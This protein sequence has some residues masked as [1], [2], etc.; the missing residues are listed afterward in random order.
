MNEDNCFIHLFRTPGGYYL[1]DVNRRV[2]LKIE[3]N[4]WQSFKNKDFSKNEELIN[5][6]KENGLLSSKRVGKIVHPIDA[7]LEH[8]LNNKACMITLQITQQCNLRCSYCIYSGDYENRE[9]SNQKMDIEIAK[10]G[11]DFLL[12]HSKDS[13]RISVGFYG[14]EPLLEF[15]LMKSVIKYAELKSEGKNIHFTFTTNAT[16]LDNEKLEFLEKY[17]VAV[18]ISLDGPKEVHDKNRK[19]AYNSCGTFDIVIDKL[20]KLREKYPRF[21][22]KNISFNAVI[23]P[24]CD[25]NCTNEFFTSYDAVKNSYVKSSIFK[26][27]YRKTEIERT[28]KFDLDLDYEYFKVF[29]AMLNRL[30][31]HYISKMFDNYMIQ[32]DKLHERLK[33]VLSLPDK[34]HHGGPCIPGVNRLFMDVK[35]RLY[36]C[37]RVSESSEIMNIGN[38]YDGFDI[39]KVSKLLNIGQVTENQCKNCWAFNHCYLCAAY[40]DELTEVSSERKGSF[41]NN[42]RVMVE[43][44]FKNYCM[45]KEFG[46]D[47][48]KN[49]PMFQEII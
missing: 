31:K 46:Y 44:D 26:D 35:G 25:F 45:L 20:D 23:D 6:M 3:E 15:D 5:A 17:D 9:H 47:F 13:D 19:F 38:I 29:L 22:E 1:Y 11:V 30:D 10:K 14:G 48:D 33:P 7:V 21:F 39:S 43:S 24:S 2:V 42:V 16:L 34:G 28:E 18:V 37:E 27:I 12:E 49:L 4:L 32:M 8:Y 36:P 41:C 40:A